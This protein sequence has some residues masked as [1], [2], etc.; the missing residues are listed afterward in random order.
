[1]PIDIRRNLKETCQEFVLQRT[2]KTAAAYAEAL[3]M[4]ENGDALSD[5]GLL[6]GVALLQRYLEADP[7]AL[8]EDWPIA[9]H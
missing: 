7:G 4:A 3:I 9:A 8:P 1:M 6:N 2:N 5:E